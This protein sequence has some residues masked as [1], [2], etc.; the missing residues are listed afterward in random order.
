MTTV[1]GSNDQF[2]IYPSDNRTEEK[3]EKGAFHNFNLVEIFFSC[4]VFPMSKT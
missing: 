2:L 1:E 4:T 3:G